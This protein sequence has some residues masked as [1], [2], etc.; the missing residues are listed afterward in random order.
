MYV[1]TAV[2][3]SC[4]KVHQ[5]IICKFAHVE[6]GRTFFEILLMHT[7]VSERKVDQMSP[8][9]KVDLLLGY[10]EGQ[11]TV[12]LLVIAVQWV[13]LE[14]NRIES[15]RVESVLARECTNHKPCVPVCKVWFTRNTPG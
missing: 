3:L 14:W 7:C 9:V 5:E 15:S 4:T 8:H 11:S 10:L 12:A 13:L 6:C 1:N 2:L